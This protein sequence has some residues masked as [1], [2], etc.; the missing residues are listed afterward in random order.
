MNPPSLT[1]ASRIHADRLAAAQRQRLIRQA[2]RRTHSSLF[3]FMVTRALPSGILFR[4]SP[5]CTVKSSQS[6]CSCLR[7]PSGR[8]SSISS[9]ILPSI[10]GSNI[11]VR[12][13]RMRSNLI[14]SSIR[15]TR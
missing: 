15:R 1:L 10:V 14:R 5:S 11:V 13:M 9:V 4:M 8:N 3:P 12:S 2:Q 6:P 7:S